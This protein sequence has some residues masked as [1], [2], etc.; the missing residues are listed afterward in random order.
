MR[1]SLYLASQ[2]RSP[3]SRLAVTLYRHPR[4]CHGALLLPLSV[5]LLDLNLSPSLSLPH[6]GRYEGSGAPEIFLSFETPDEA[7]TLCGF[8]RLR[9]PSCSVTAPADDS[10]LYTPLRSSTECSARLKPGTFRYLSPVNKSLHLVTH[11]HS[12]SIQRLLAS[13][14]VRLSFPYHSS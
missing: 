10:C 3:A 8:L 9:L 12:L 11:C 5:S 7:Q 2:Q 1:R 6:R 13:H 4:S 14:L